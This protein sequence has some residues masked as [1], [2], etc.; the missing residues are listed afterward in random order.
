M[1]QLWQSVSTGKA[2]VIDVPAP[3]AGRDQILV[4]VMASLISSGTERSVVEFAGKNLIQKAMSRPDLVK[5]LK[6][7]ASREGW[8]TALEGARRKLDTEM[9]L[10]YSNAGIVIEVGEGVS[11]FRVGDHVACAGGGFASH[12]EIVRIPRN[13]AAVLPAGPGLREVPFEEMAFATVASVGLQ[14]IR[15]AELQLGEIVAVIGLGLIGQ[16]TIQLARANGCV[17]IGMDPSAERCR[18]AERMGASATASSDEQMQLMAARL[19]SGRG[20]DSILITA[21]TES[22]GPVTVAAE[23]A[24]DRAKVVAIGAVGLSLP[25]KPYYMKEL[26]FR[27]SRSYGPGRYD[28]EYEEKGNDY[29][30]GYVRWTEGRNVAAIL[31]MLTT[32]QLDFAPLISHR[33][34]IEQAEKGYELIAGKSGAP[35]MAV[36][37]TYPNEPSIARRIDLPVS[38]ERATA[39]SAVRLGLLGA[40]NFATATLLP[41]IKAAGN[42]EFVGVCASGGSGARS[43]GNR[44]GFRF[45][46]SDANEFLNDESINTI[47]ICTR[48]SGHAEQV[49]SAFNSGKHV[50]CEKPLA[51]NEE[52][53]AAIIHAYDRQES[54]G[55][56]LVGYN[57]RFAPLAK[58]LR[59]FVENCSEPFVMHYRVNAGFIPADHWV[60]DPDQGGGRILGEVCHFVDFLSFVCGHLVTGVS[61]QVTPNSGRYCDDNLMAALRFSDGSVGTILYTANGDKAFSKER[62]EIFVQGRVGVLDDY[63]MLQTVR[64]GKKRVTNTHLRVDKGH[65]GEWEAFG[66]AIRSGG[67]SPISLHEIVNSTLATIALARS[68]AHGGWVEVD[69]DGFL[70]RTRAS[71]SPAEQEGAL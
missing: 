20:V 55:L 62:A 58:R 9:I 12:S 48:H 18:L 54:Q 29:P 2:T 1:K 25:R 43:V 13:L 24:R 8:V 26:D 36:V 61:V 38:D 52:E 39:P 69:S 40:G 59:A 42:I 64:E 23:I 45:C 70:A 65:R 6:E 56:L 53:L 28:P 60:Q 5:Q 33:F 41:A 67:S 34:P 27:V 15:L 57:R 63:R 30:I 37:I 17:V 14:G 51:M 19:S 7:K 22:N 32:G 66:E 21:A 68:A 50:F 11:D 4:R 31:Q 16:I 3:H 10:G 47:A 44:Y 35:T 49:V 71:R 46:T